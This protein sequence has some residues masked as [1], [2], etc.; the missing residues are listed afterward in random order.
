LP[1]DVS[2]F[3]LLDALQERGFQASAI[4]TYS[5]YF[6]FFEEV[7]LRRLLDRGCINNVLFVDAGRCA[8]AFASEE[9]RPRRAGSDY[10]L[11][12][13]HL[14]GAF[15]PK[16]IVR[17]GK[18]K[19]SLL[20][21]S[22]NMTLAGF[23]L[24]DELTNEFRT[25]GQGARQGAE[26]IRLAL[27]YLHLFVPTNLPELAQAFTSVRL[28]I[29]WL[30]G[31]ISLPSDDRFLMT[32]TGRDPD[33]WSR[34]RPLIPKRRV[35]VFTCGP[36]FDSN[37]GFL[38]KL[39]N[40]VKPDR[41]VVG[42]DP[43]SVEINLATVSS[44]P[45]AQFVNISG[46]LRIPN[47]RNT[48]STY[49][50]AKILSFKGSDGEL[51]VTGS[52]NPSAPAFLSDVDRRN[53]EAIVVDRRTGSAAGLG[54]DA[55]VNAPSVTEDDWIQV[56]SRQ[57][58]VAETKSPVCGTLILAV[59]TEVGFIA[60]QPIGKKVLLD[61]FA[62]DSKALGQAVTSNDDETLILAPVEVRDGAQTLRCTRTL[63]SPVTL[64]VHRPEEVARNV[65]SNR[66]RELRRALGALEEDPAQLDTLLKLTEK[67]IFDSDDVIT[68]ASP[69]VRKPQPASDQRAK[70]T[71]PESLAVEAAGRRS[72]RKKKSLASG[73]ILVLLDALMYR[74]GEGL[75]GRTVLPEPG[76]NDDGDPNG[77]NGDDKRPPTQPPPYELLAHAC[78]S[79]VGRL[80]RRMIKQL[81]HA[82]SASARR[83]I[84]QLAAVLS[85]IH[86]LRSME[87]RVEWRSKHLVLVDSDHEWEIFEKGSLALTWGA[88]AL[89]PRALQEGDR[90]PFK[91]M[92]LAI[93]LL[94]WLAW[95]M[96][97][98]VKA[99]VER[100]KP[101]DPEQNDDPW[102]PIQILASAAPALAADEEAREHFFAAVNRTPRRGHDVKLWLA[103]HTSF[104]ERLEKIIAS[105]DRVRKADRAPQPGDLVILRA[106]LDPR[107]RVAL[108]VAPSGDTTK[109]TV[110]DDENEECER[111]ILAT[112][113][114]YV[115]CMGPARPLQTIGNGQS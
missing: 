58:L 70:S 77:G 43:E 21:G 112:H 87:Q 60:Q 30:E 98:D 86:M 71:G 8:E 48:V 55:L 35:T 88:K 103:T 90:E 72:A 100:K 84:V 26:I 46:M 108:T 40:H 33:L 73:D 82:R 7:V 59:P 94:A 91:E 93:A 2:S 44:V 96:H 19:G 47:R 54:I 52:A 65:G 102:Y 31:P 104:A 29:P 80:V 1:K 51:L 20:V 68:E 113:V 53:A 42:I 56:K 3:P 45:G 49:L 78:R 16:L 66:Q 92:S 101:L 5:C 39:V 34:L 28:N 17:I 109:I 4:A 32:T 50:H 6:P 13:V 22:H 10:T 27:D 25:S 106:A 61:A 81:E 12:P 23:G 110:L 79:K 11:I 107:V 64:L 67:V 18:S 89:V 76:T 57:T 41:L 24:N 62:S 38:K 36:F 74:L 9:T 75:A 97:V 99:A 115:A 105:P 111:H 83:A 85:V 14:H 15:H 63:R 114:N 37:L 95:E 69:A